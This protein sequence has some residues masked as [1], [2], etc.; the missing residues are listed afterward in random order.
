MPNL[1]VI[2]NMHNLVPAG[3]YAALTPENPY[4]IYGRPYFK[5]LKSN[6]LF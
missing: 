4:S 2:Q 6:V 5:L 3:A 1:K